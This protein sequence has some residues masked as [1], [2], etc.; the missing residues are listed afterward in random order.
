[1]VLVYQGLN[2]K[3][4]LHRD[5]IG[6]MISALISYTKTYFNKTI[7]IIETDQFRFSIYYLKSF[8]LFAIGKSSVKV[9]KNEVYKTMK[10]FI[11]D[12]MAILK[13]EVLKAKY[14]GNL[15][16]LA[17]SSKIMDLDRALN[18]Y[19]SSALDSKIAFFS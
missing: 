14:D 5:I 1:M 11:R 15:T 6:G 8:E 7:H 19:P 2:A 13:P 3:H 18:W 10:H 9:S 4:I 16:P 17:E 12:F